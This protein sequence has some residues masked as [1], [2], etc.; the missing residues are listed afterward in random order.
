MRIVSFSEGTHP[1]NGSVGIAAV[2]AICRSLYEQGNTVTLVVGN[3]P[4]QF[5]E[6][7]PLSLDYLKKKSQKGNSLEMVH[8]P[9][10]TK[11]AFAPK[12]LL[13]FKLVAQ[14]D[15]IFLHSLYSFP[16]LVGYIFSKIYKKPYL[17]YTHGVLAPFQRQVSFRKKV[18]YNWLIAKSILD[19]ASTIV[20]TSSGEME[21]AKP[22]KIKA[23]AAIIPHGVDFAASH[24]L[25]DK[26]NFRQKYLG[27]HTGP[28]LL[29]LG[30]LNAKKGLDILI[31]SFSVIQKEIP[32]ARMV[33][34]GGGDPPSFET[35]VRDWVSEFGLGQKV[36]FTGP[37]F[38]QEKYSAFAGS[39]VFILPSIAENFCMTMFEAMSFHLPVIISEN[40]NL[41]ADVKQARA[42]LVVKRDA[43]S[44]A[45]STISL[46][47]DEKLKS[48]LSQNGFQFAKTFSWQKTG[49]KLNNLIHNVVDIAKEC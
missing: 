9:G 16:V 41:A 20:Y 17:L 3:N 1:A 29:Y 15:I 22:L 35:K 38:G 40:L 5:L 42:G 43:Q 4:Y 34:V 25:N 44:F 32:D 47:E 30:R 31:E 11:W 49:E 33:I 13:S 45:N 6:S 19:N 7:T 36:V 28:V 24:I 12:L 10:L 2:P 37:L 23:P 18:I 14:A 46:L 8:A 48:E 27:G 39:D 21:E 26:K